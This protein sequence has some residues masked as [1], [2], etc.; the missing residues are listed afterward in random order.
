MRPWSFTRPSA[1][2]THSVSKTLDPRWWVQEHAG[3]KGAG[4]FQ[5][6][7]HYSNLRDFGRK[8]RW[9]VLLYIT[10]VLANVFRG[11]KWHSYYVPWA[12]DLEIILRVYSGWDN[13]VMPVA[14]LFAVIQ[15]VIAYPVVQLFGLANA[16]LILSYVSIL[17][18]SYIAIYPLRDTFSWLIPSYR[19]RVL[20]CLAIGCGA[21][22]TEI[23]STLIGTA[24]YFGLYALLL[25]LE[26]P[27]APPKML[28]VSIFLLSLSTNTAVIALPVILMRLL[29]DQRRARWLGATG[30]IVLSALC[31]LLISTK[32]YGAGRPSDIEALLIAMVNNWPVW[33][34]AAT[35]LS[36]LL[37]FIA[38]KSVEASWMGVSLVGAVAVYTVAYLFS[39]G[40]LYFKE[41]PVRL[42]AIDNPLNRH[43]F[44]FWV[45]VVV[46]LVMGISRFQVA[47]LRRWGFGVLM[48]LVV[49]CS[50]AP[51][52][53]P[54]SQFFGKHSDSFEGDWSRFCDGLEQARARGSELRETDHRISI[55]ICPCGNDNSLGVV[56]CSTDASGLTCA[57][58]LNSEFFMV[59]PKR[60]DGAKSG[61]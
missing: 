20:V 24:Y 53:V 30:I 16:P 8:H 47:S 42:P 36:L 10:I 52:V 48:S 35:V 4:I 9:A 17:I 58:R 18:I 41:S 57:I 12:E 13:L 34:L 46:L 14:D 7:I 56:N 49:G 23:A 19:C 45:V 15:K 27:S 28:L 32:T 31:S 39:R 1:K 22:S 43:G 61:T 55:E 40:A 51:L 2:E 29:L 6:M 50:L 37:L 59:F 33:I 21:G 54:I 38:R 60:G 11:W 25:A 26:K 44:Y 3:G 5:G